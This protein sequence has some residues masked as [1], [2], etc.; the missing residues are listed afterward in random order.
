[1]RAPRFPA[2]RL[3]WGDVLR[4]IPRLERYDPAGKRDRIVLTAEGRYAIGMRDDET[5]RG[6]FICA[7][8]DV[9]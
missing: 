3:S 4:L 7:P 9:P 1:M 8:D 5:G 2:A 6:G